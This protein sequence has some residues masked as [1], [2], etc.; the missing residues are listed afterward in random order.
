MGSFRFEGDKI[1]LT[2]DDGI[3]LTYKMKPTPSYKVGTIY[4]D[5]NGDRYFLEN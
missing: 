5:Y 3:Y 1:I 2:Y 4:F